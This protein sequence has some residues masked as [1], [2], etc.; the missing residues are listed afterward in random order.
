MNLVAKEYLAAQNPGR[1]PACWCCRN[2]LA[3]AAQE[4]NAALLVNPYDT[5]EVARALHQAIY[6]PVVA[7]RIER[8]ETSIRG[9]AQSQP[10]CWYDSFFAALRSAFD[11]A[12]REH[13]NPQRRLA[14]E[15]ESHGPAVAPGY[16]RDRMARTSIRP[17]SDHP[18]PQAAAELGVI[19]G[20]RIAIERVYP[21]LE[22][23][24]YAVK[25]VVLASG[26]TCGPISFATRWP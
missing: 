6:M 20:P 24:R 21:D 17:V 3:G 11:Q 12:G 8:W 2:L 26:S 19:P 10:A 5:E 7:E 1:I 4:L 23:G 14:K 22:G 13:R 16:S 18:L 25:R 9:V 15:Q